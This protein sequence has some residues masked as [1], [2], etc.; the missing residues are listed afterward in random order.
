MPVRGILVASDFPEGVQY[1]ARAMPNLALRRY[2]IQL[3]F[4]D[5]SLGE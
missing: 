4:E 1:A 5:A 2:H 3:A